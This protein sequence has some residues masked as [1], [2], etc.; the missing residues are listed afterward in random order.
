MI[1]KKWR[2]K[3]WGKKN[4]LMQYKNNPIVKKKRY[5]NEKGGN[6]AKLYADRRREILYPLPVLQTINRTPLI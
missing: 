4:I 2:K 3:W 6:Q 1:M 5:K